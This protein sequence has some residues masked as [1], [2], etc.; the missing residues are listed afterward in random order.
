MKLEDHSASASHQETESVEPL[1]CGLSE[2][3]PPDTSDPVLEVYQ[4]DVD[5]TLLRANLALTPA[6]R[7]QKLAISFVFLRNCGSPVKNSKRKT[8]EHKLR[9]DS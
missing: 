6:E 7:G 1:H 5:R 9:E 2:L 4:R 3:P 8:G